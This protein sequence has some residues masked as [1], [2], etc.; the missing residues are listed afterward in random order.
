MMLP[1]AIIARVMV[2]ML[3]GLAYSLSQ[4]NVSWPL[5]LTLLFFL[6][7]LFFACIFCHTAAYALRPRRASEATLFYLLFAAGGALGSFFI[8]IVSPL[9]FSL[10]LDLPLTFF[11]TAALALVLN[12]RGAWSQRLLWIVAS[13]AMLVL[14]FWVRAAYLHDT[15]VTVRNFYASLRVTQDHSYPGATLRTLLNGSIQHGTQIFGTDELRQTPTTYYAPGSGVGL[16]LKR[17]GR[18]PALAAL[19]ARLSRQKALP[20]RRGA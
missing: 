13:G 6:V 4:T 11:V 15:M 9:L 12:W 20:A 7:E 19:G 16:A 10:N 2:V 8:G 17:T 18:L 1:W 5:W 14:V 3:G